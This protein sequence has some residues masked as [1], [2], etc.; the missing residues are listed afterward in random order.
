MNDKTRNEILKYI[1]KGERVEET[2]TKLNLTKSEV[3][4]CVDD[5]ISILSKS[6]K[7]VDIQHNPPVSAFETFK[8][9]LIIETLSALNE[10][11]YVDVVAQELLER[12][13]QTIVIDEKTTAETLTTACLLKANKRDISNNRRGTIVMSEGTSQVADLTHRQGKKS[14]KDDGIHKI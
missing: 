10:K 7:S 9:N 5:C 1:L 6:S 8:N 3:Q 13:L 14:K 2:A 11:G 4:K 12:T